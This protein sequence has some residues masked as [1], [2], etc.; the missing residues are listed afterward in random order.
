MPSRRSHRLF[1]EDANGHFSDRELLNKQ[2]RISI[3]TVVRNNRN[4]IE[5]CIQSVI[6]Q[7]CT[8]IEYIVIDGASTDGTLDIIDGYKDRI[9]RIVSEKDKGHIFAMN[10]GLGLASGDVVGFLHSDD[11]YAD[12][13]VIE[14][15]ANSFKNN[16]TD[17]LYGDLVYVTKNNPDRIV[18]Y[19][20]GRDYDVKSL[21]W[22]W[23]PAHPTFFVRKNIYEKYGYFNT[24]FKISTDYENMLRFLYRYKISAQY[25]PET[26]V[27]MRFG[28]VSNRS[29]KNII[30]K[31]VED[32]RACRMHELG[33]STVIMKNI[34]KLP[35]FRFFGI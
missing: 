35:Q 30:R 10:K 2:M 22:G 7:T 13:T 33:L 1:F 18:R 9:S 12:N 4:M 34:M 31:T 5:D 17:S 26:I 29:V 3:I 21:R 19:W 8:D 23:M 15:I 6:G 16:D 32:Y 20:R 27:K 11:F 14:K 24:D 28:G 25:L